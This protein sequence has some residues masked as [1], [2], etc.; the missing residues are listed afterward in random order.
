MDGISKRRA[1]LFEESREL[2]LL[3]DA[4]VALLIISADGHEGLSFWFFF[5]EMAV[6]KSFDL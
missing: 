2:A 5:L 4:E 3:Y 6:T 1:E